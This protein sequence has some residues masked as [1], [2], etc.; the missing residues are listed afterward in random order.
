MARRH[1]GAPVR[2]AQ[3][4]TDGFWTIDVALA[5][6]A[7]GETA[8]DLTSARFLR[9]E[10]EPGTAAHS[11]CSAHRIGPTVPLSFGG[12]VVID[13]DGPFLELHPEDDFRLADRE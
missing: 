2:D 4:S 10:V 8:A 1:R 12:A 5:A 9:L 13:T 6:F 11:V 7:I 3:H